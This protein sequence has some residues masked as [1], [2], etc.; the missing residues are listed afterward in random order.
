MKIAFYIKIKVLKKGYDVILMKYV[1]LIL[2]IICLFLFSILMIDTML[3]IKKSTKK[4]LEEIRNPILKRIRIG[5]ILVILVG[6]L[7]IIRIIMSGLS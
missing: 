6:I 1:I 4:R 7:T 5:N 2:D 3:L